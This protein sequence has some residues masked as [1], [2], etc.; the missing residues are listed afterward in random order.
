MSEVTSD[1][2]QDVV[3]PQ[4]EMD[5][6]SATATSEAEEKSGLFSSMT[7]YDTMLVLSF[8]FIAVA[9]LRLFTVLRVYSEGFPFGGFPWKTSE[10]QFLMWF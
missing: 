5:S 4:A 2:P 9:T 3:D 10:Y 8:V 1:V 7:I 6:D